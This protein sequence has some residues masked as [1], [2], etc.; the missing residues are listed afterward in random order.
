[1]R[2]FYSI[3]AVKFVLRLASDIGFLLLFAL[4]LDG[5]ATRQ[6]LDLLAPHLPHYRIEAAFACWVAAIAIDRHTQHVR[7]QL[8]TALVPAMRPNRSPIEYLVYV[9][10]M[11][12]LGAV[13]LRLL[14][15]ALTSGAT[16]GVLHGDGHLARGLYEVYQTTISLDVVLVMM[17]LLTFFSVSQNFG[18]LVIMLGQMVSD[19]K[20]FFQ[21]LL[22]IILAFCLAFL[23]MSHGTSVHSGHSDFHGD[24]VAVEHPA[25]VTD[26]L[27]RRQLK[28]GGSGAAA[29][30]SAAAVASR[31]TLDGNSSAVFGGGVFGSTGLTSAVWVPF[32]AVYGDFDTDALE[33]EA[34]FSSPI[35][36][37]Y[38]LVSNVVLVNLLVAMFADTYSKVKENAD[39]EFHYQSFERTFLHERVLSSTPPPLNLIIILLQPF[40]ALV[41]WLRGCPEF[42]CPK[43]FRERVR[44]REERDYGRNYSPLGDTP[45]RTAEAATEW[46]DLPSINLLQRYQ[47]KVESDEVEA[48][49]LS[50][51]VTSLLES[52]DVTNS[53]LARV[54]ERVEQLH[55]LL[56]PATANATPLNKNDSHLSGLSVSE[57]SEVGGAGGTPEGGKARRASKF[58]F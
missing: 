56:G 45:R 43:S 47:A 41:N 14:S 16:D 10:D 8:Y 32:W 52:R 31:V 58:A 25:D 19:I 54:A 48:K 15:A 21:L 46:Q 39:T 57:P 18:V 11:V 4:V 5:T 42:W 2:T 24:P 50:S 40:R 51:T 33:D 29:A 20:N 49:Y 27:L 36:W 13:T 23:G 28:S 26:D 17:R 7:A 53:R 38:V 9:G 6:Q 55:S 22:V 44:E 37:V 12:L 1:M 34:P 3:P 35:L 30:A